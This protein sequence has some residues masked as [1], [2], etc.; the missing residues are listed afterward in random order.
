MKLLLEHGDEENDN[1]NNPP[2]DCDASPEL[3]GIF[4]IEYF[5]GCQSIFPAI[6]GRHE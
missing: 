5:C 6:G 2:L 4:P 3:S 1:T